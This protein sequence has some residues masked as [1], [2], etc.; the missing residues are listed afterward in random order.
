MLLFVFVSVVLAVVVAASLF[1]LF[2]LVALILL[3]LAV[4][5]IDGRAACCRCSASTRSRRVRARFGLLR[6]LRFHFTSS[7]GRDG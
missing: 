2:F 3:V 7:R 6:T 5:H 4:G 1:R